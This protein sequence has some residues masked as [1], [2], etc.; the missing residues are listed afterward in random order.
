LEKEKMENRERLLKNKKGFMS[1][2]K[3][4]LALTRGKVSDIYK[5]KQNGNKISHIRDTKRE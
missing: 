5:K 3:E 2:Y 4:E 1:K